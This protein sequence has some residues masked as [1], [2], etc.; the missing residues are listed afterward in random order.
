MVG[1]SA[2]SNASI[3][4]AVFTISL[5]IKESINTGWFALSPREHLEEGEDEENSS[6]EEEV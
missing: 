5:A 1:D 3:T 2:G 6:E 4:G